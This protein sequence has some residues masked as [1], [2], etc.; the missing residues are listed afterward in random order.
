MDIS[1]VRDP[2]E[3]CSLDDY[4]NG[5]C[6]EAAKHTDLGQTAVAKDGEWTF[7][8]CNANC[9]ANDGDTKL[10]HWVPAVTPAEVGREV[11]DAIVALERVELESHLTKLEK[12]LANSFF[13]NG[14]DEP[15]E[16]HLGKSVALK[17][18]IEDQ[19][20][21]LAF[22]ER[23]IGNGFCRLSVPGDGNCLCWSLFAL[24]DKVCKSDVFDCDDPLQ[25]HR[26][27]TLRHQIS[28]VWRL[29]KDSHGLQTLYKRVYVPDPQEP[30]CKIERTEQPA[31]VTPDRVK[32]AFPHVVDL[33]TPPEAEEKRTSKDVKR[34]E[35]CKRAP[36][37]PSIA[38]P[39]TLFSGPA[40][41]DGRKD[42][43]K[44]ADDKG[45]QDEGVGQNGLP[46]GK[47][48]KKE[49]KGQKKERKKESKQDEIDDIP[50]VPEAPLR[51]SAEDCQA[52]G[53]NQETLQQ[54]KRRRVARKRNKTDQEKR[55]HKLKQY[56]TTIGIGYGEWMAMHWRI[57]GSKKA[58]ACSEG[59]Y[60]DFLARLLAGAESSEC[61]A[62]KELLKNAGYDVLAAE[63]FEVAD[64]QAKAAPED[65]EQCEEAAPDQDPEG[66][67]AAGGPKSDLQSML[68]ETELNRM[69]HRISIYF[70]T[71]I[72]LMYFAVM[73]VVFFNFKAQARS[74]E[75]KAL[76]PG[77]FL[78]KQLSIFKGFK[79]V[80]H[81]R[82]EVR[83]SNPPITFSTWS[84]SFHGPVCFELW[85]SLPFPSLP[86]PSLPGWSCG[87]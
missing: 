40:P 61:A 30:P 18:A 52:D 19:N 20:D 10:N 57:S 9:R 79:K 64:L 68:D 70:Q 45:P 15:L 27:Q 23:C 37:W 47:K 29:G 48:Q 44:C 43:E 63:E 66:A 22:F 16:V 65:E 14:K 58:G 33:D 26:V 31:P 36:A 6:P 62:C 69:A 59:L 8:H 38:A 50:E 74:V 28:L 71:K 56:L 1:N 25:L 73:I 84:P 17:M 67:E 53:G 85:A 72:N 34:V 76:S 2:L 7:V 87:C 11:Y 77:S 55:L 21:R 49:D 60:K 82:I 75:L 46:D 51:S 5:I 35:S 3:R 81:E 4:M 86:F 54:P 32:K 80:F 12:D 41:A 83:G 42:G 39:Q 13:S 78:F 24:S